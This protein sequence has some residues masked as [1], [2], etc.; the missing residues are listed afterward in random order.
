MTWCQAPLLYGLG[1]VMVFQAV[2]MPKTSHRHLQWLRARRL[3]QPHPLA[4][5]PTIGFFAG[6]LDEAAIYN[7]TLN[8]TDAQEHHRGA[9]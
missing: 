9:P 6:S 8:A 4:L 5:S 3:R 1:L 2:L 7:K